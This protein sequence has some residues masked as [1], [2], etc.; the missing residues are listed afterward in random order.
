VRQRLSSYG[1]P[2]SNPLAGEAELIPETPMGNE[3]E[4]NAA[5]ESICSSMC[6]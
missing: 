2:G 4:T 5:K 3:E 6:Q 1:D